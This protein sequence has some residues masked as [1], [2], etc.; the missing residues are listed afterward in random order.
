MSFPENEPETGTPQDGVLTRKVRSAR[1]SIFAER[2]WEALLWPL[3]TV[4]LFVALSLLGVFALMPGWLH[5]FALVLFAL[6]LVISCRGFLQLR[7]PGREQALRRL[8]RDAGLKHRPAT[9]YNDTLGE[10]A[11]REGRALWDAHRSRLASLFARLKPGWPKP[12]NDRAD[13]Y[14]LR[15][16]LALVLLVA[17]L[18][19]GGSGLDRLRA[20]LMPQSI[21][22]AA[23]LRVDAWVTPPAYTGKPPIVLASGSV[24]EQKAEPSLPLAVPENSVLVLR[25]LSPDGRPVS[26]R[27]IDSKG[28]VHGLT[29][30]G[31][32]PKADEGV[33]VEFEQTLENPVTLELES[34]GAALAKWSFS[35][36][37]DQPPRIA[38]SEMP[39]QTP[40]AAVRFGY[41]AE[42]DYGVVQADARFALTDEKADKTKLGDASL[43]EPPSIPITLP[44]SKSE[45]VEGHATKD[46]TSH[47]WAGLKVKMT[48]SARDHAG[49]RGESE[50]HEFILPERVFTKP[51]AKAL[52]AQR[53]DLVLELDMSQR[54]ADELDKIGRAAE[55]QLSDAGIYLALRALHW[56]LRHDPST[57]AKRSVVDE[58][59]QLALKIEDGDLPEAEKNMRE[60]Q[61]R[62]MDA[63]KN[64]ASDAEIEKL[65]DELRQAMS[66]FLKQLQ[67][68]QANRSGDPQ[69]QPQSETGDETVSQQ[70]LDKLLDSIEQLAKSGAKD[71]AERMLSEMKDVLERL[72]NG[73]MAQ[74]AE[75]QQM[76]KSMKELQD[77]I[78]EQQKLLDDT[79][80]ARRQ[81]PQPPGGEGQQG[82]QQSDMQFNP[83]GEHGDP[84]GMEGFMGQDSPF[85]QFGMPQFGEQ[86]QQ[87]EGKQR[88]QGKQAQQGKQGKQGKGQQ[89]QGQKGGQGG[90]S[91]GSQSELG[92]RQAGLQQRLQDMMEQMRGTGGQ[93][94]GELDGANAAMGDAQ[95]AI[96]EKNLERATDQQTLALDRLRQGAQSM[97]DQMTQGQQ[98]GQQGQKQGQRGPGRNG[99]RDP[100]G[101]PERSEGP[102]LGLSVK[103]P[104]EIDVQRAREILDEVR[105]RLGDPNRPNL[106][107]DYLE[108]LIRR[109]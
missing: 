5:L 102:D 70:D 90:R 105:R 14:A 4:G 62:L 46:L 6:A 61:E 80:E 73:N 94:P 26:L 76:A 40:R 78:R 19:T 2:V 50:P 103:V 35:I 42:D 99:M 57:D 85:G 59:W 67:Q 82:E 13:P 18:A 23:P 17:V 39:T 51:L 41:A 88:Q 71:L 63:L 43:V 75:Q 7:Y 34:D 66:E 16:G 29:P 92:K 107:L 32:A 33:P 11:T 95:G 79:F 3:V 8:E 60:A 104:D 36:V 83:D 48:L 22:S 12:R 89:G 72:Q 44:R 45:F 108:R 68:Q 81:E 27:R 109:F 24:P 31:D 38:L 28:G 1:L 69:N 30:K 84:M 100:L 15:I 77:M 58:L 54:V 65:V 25:A 96:G 49:Q 97:A 86:G 101:R 20:A 91:P 10:S 52:V 37:D 9:S 93:P 74:N 47:P 106:E 64:N 98:Q 53:R 56:R 87:G 21:A 55:E